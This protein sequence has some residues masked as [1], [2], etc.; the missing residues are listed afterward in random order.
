MFI[1]TLDSI[2]LRSVGC[3]AKKK[4]L[5]KKLIFFSKEKKSAIV[6]GRAAKQ[7]AKD[8]GNY[9]VKTIKKNM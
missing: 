3:K 8:A 7:K 5:I 2:D 1:R 6:T 9:V 4:G